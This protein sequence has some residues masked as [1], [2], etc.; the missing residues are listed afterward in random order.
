M[1]I[2]LEGDLQVSSGLNEYNSKSFHYEARKQYIEWFLNNPK[3]NNEESIFFSLGDLTESSLPSPRDTELLVYYYSNLKHHKKYILAGNHDF[4]RDKNTYSFAPLTKLSKV[5]AFYKPQDLTIGSSTIKVLPY[6]YDHIFPDM[7]SMKEEYESYEGVYDLILF[8]FED[9]TQ[10]FGNG[11]SINIK[12]KGKRV[13]GHIHVGGQNYITS[14]LPN[15]SNEVLPERHIYIYD[16][17]TKEIE[18]EIIP[19]FLDYKVVKFPEPIERRDE[20]TP[21]VAFEIRDYVNKE[22]ALKLY[23]EQW[24]EDF[25]VH[26]MVKQTLLESGDT[27][28]SDK[29]RSVLELW[30]DYK[31]NNKVDKKVSEIV[32]EQIK[33]ASSF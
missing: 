16:T 10:D 7:K 17:E 28:R 33:Q 30:E 27:E 12:L 15:K 9:E 5:E 1:K 11:G 8:H 21:F 4:S 29:V 22:E 14:P 19:N 3:L 25:Y 26:K 31:N 2:V 24:G 13:G 23:R 20:D 32:Y 18:K 6:F